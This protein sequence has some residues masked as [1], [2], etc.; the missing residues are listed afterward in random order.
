MLSAVL[1]TA[2]STGVAL[3]ATGAESAPALGRSL[4]GQINAVRAAHG[5]RPLRMQPGLARAATQ[6]SSEMVA[7][8]YF[9]HDSA[10]GTSFQARIASFYP[11]G[12]LTGENLVWASGAAT[13]DVL[14]GAWLQSPAHRRN[15][16][17]VR[18]RD[19]GLAAVI[20]TRAP[21]AFAGR[22]VT[23][24]TIDLGSR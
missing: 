15:L 10:D 4:M 22:T 19:A 24:V 14:L 9:G 5:L 20:A 1:L 17:D 3:A 18:Y 13:A 23:V 12:R 11:R 8:G 7:R 6:H 2:L 21:G 16:L